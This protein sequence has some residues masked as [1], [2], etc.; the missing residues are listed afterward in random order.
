MHILVALALLA[1]PE[2]LIE[3]TNTIAS[4]LEGLDVAE[5]QASPVERYVVENLYDK[6]NGRSELFMAYGVTGL[7]FITLKHA[8]DPGRYVDIFLYDMTTAPGA[9]G[10]F[11]VERWPGQETLDIGRGAYRNGNDLFFWKGPYYASLLGSGKEPTV[12]DAQFAIAQQLAKTLK[13]SDEALWGF[14]VLPKEHVAA[15]TIQYFMVDALSLSFMT[16]TYTAEFTTGGNEISAF[17]SRADTPDAAR[18]R[19]DQYVAYMN[20]YGVK[21][22]TLGGDGFTLGDMGGGY[23]DVIFQEGS[24][25]AGVTAVPNRDTAVAAARAWRDALALKK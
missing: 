18:E 16:D 4:A 9:F 14:E 5:W 6:I 21:I 13:D 23:Y 8:E 2:N 25:V 24:Y 15:D 7:A 19:H 22:E 3:K 20:Q 1:A 17:V 10:V 11:S 12:H